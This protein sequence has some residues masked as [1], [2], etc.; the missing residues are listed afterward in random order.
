[1]ILRA[2][3][4]PFDGL[5]QVSIKPN[6]SK[7]TCANGA[8]TRHWRCGSAKQALHSRHQCV[9][10]QIPLPPNKHLR[11]PRPQRIKMPASK[12]SSVSLPPS[13]PFQAKLIFLT[14]SQQAG[15]LCPC[16]SLSMHGFRS[17]AASAA[18][19]PRFV[20]LRDGDFSACMAF[21]REPKTPAVFPRRSRVACWVV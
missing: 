10:A 13:M 3:R 1:M 16:G 6:K 12:I 17:V 19:A 20:E 4:V 8:F 5:V 2:C 21:D 15:C 7:H 11:T 18:S 9:H 14:V